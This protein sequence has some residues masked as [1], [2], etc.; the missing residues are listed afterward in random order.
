MPLYVDPLSPSKV[1]SSTRSDAFEETPRPEVGGSVHGSC[2]DTDGEDNGDLHEANRGSFLGN[3]QALDAPVKLAVTL[4][5]SSYGAG[6]TVAGSVTVGC[7]SA[8]NA[9]VRRAAAVLPPAG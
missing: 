7:S 1:K 9:R 3:G 2:A 5:A 4:N 8:V 6:D